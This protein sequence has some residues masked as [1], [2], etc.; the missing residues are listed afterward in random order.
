MQGVKAL[1]VDRRELD[2]TTWGLKSSEGLFAGP[3]LRVSP[4]R[5]PPH[6]RVDTCP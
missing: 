2:S 6:T 5:A 3:L 4:T 1:E